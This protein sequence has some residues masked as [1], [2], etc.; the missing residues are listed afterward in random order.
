MKLAVAT[1]APRLLQNV[2]APPAAQTLTVVHAGTGLVADP[3]LRA[4]R[5]RTQVPLAK[6]WRLFKVHQLF[7]AWP[8]P[9]RE[10]VVVVIVMLVMIVVVVI[11]VVGVIQLPIVPIVSLD[12]CGDVEALFQN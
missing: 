11:I 5:V 7:A 9:M 2:V 1:F 3:T 6:I 10:V 8:P 4:P 12:E